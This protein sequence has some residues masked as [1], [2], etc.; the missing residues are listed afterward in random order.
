MHN[1]AAAI[2]QVDLVMRHASAIQ[3]QILVFVEVRARISTRYG[4]AAASIGPAKQ[5][6]IAR[7][8]QFF[9]KTNQHYRDWPIRFDAVT[10]QGSSDTISWLQ[11][12]FEC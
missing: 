10:V 6:R 4:G 5:A 8:A 12:A 7:A 2:D 9:V 3:A 11:S 1:V